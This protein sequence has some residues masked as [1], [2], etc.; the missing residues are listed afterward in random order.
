VKTLNGI[1]SSHPI[2]GLEQRRPKVRCCAIGL[3]HFILKQYFRTSKCW[4][5]GVAGIT[6]GL[7][8]EIYGGSTGGLHRFGKRFSMGP[9]YV[10]ASHQLVLKLTTAIV[11]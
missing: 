1:T 9:A 4:A 6:R 8:L 5:G 11:V 3:S 10:G 2:N 7:L